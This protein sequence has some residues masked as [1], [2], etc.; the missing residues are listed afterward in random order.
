MTSLCAATGSADSHGSEMRTQPVPEFLCSGAWRCLNATHQG[1][2][3]GARPR[4]ITL[5]PWKHQS[6]DYTLL[7]KYSSVSVLLWI[8]TDGALWFP[9]KE[10]SDA[11]LFSLHPSLIL[12]AWL[13]SATAWSSHSW[14]RSHTVTLLLHSLTSLLSVCHLLFITLWF[15][16]VFIFHL[17]FPHCSCFHYRV[18]GFKGRLCRPSHTHLRFLGNFSFIQLTIK[19][20]LLYINTN[21]DR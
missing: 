3:S 4:E 17:I 20:L 6:T 19:I 7:G 21:I 10:S 13:E 14:L 16:K 12:P 2:P 1:S 5:T 9:N 8:C 15:S 11:S 18:S